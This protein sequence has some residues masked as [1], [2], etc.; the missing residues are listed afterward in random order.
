MRVLH[1][2]RQ[3]NGHGM[4]PCDQT[5]KISAGSKSANEQRRTTDTE[6]GGI[7]PGKPA[8]SNSS[9]SDWESG[10][11]YP[12]L[13]FYFVRSF[14]FS[15]R[16]ISFTGSSILIPSSHRLGKCRSDQFST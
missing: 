2:A 15:R 11:L 8:S 5:R 10:N 12:Q 1:E 13:F 16:R 3:L 14:T 9:V 4:K 6:A 7:Q